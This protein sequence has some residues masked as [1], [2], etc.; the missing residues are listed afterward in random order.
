MKQRANVTFASVLCVLIVTAC[1]QNADYPVLKGPYLGQRPP[2]DVPVLFAP[3]IVADIY[4]EHSGA[5]FTPDGKELFWTVDNIGRPWYPRIVLFMKQVNGVWSQPEMASFVLGKITHI[6]SI[7][8]DGKRL[9]F[10]SVRPVKEGDEPTG[11]TWVID[12]KEMGWGVPYLHNTVNNPRTRLTD[13]QEAKSGTLY[14]YGTIGDDP[15]WRG[16]LRAKYSNGTYEALESLGPHVNSEYLDHSVT[17]DADEQYIIFA[18]QRP[19]GYS[20]QDLYISFRHPDDTWG[21]AHNL[22]EV[23]NT[24]GD[25]QA[26]PHLSSDGKYLFFV[27][28]TDPYP[29]LYDKQYSYQELRQISS[30]VM[31]GLSNIYWVSTGFVDSLKSEHF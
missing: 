19:G 12:K 31:N 6:N 14:G 17:V 5:V 11:N 16:I 4:R 10:G 1:S 20:A 18:S 29:D 21:P 2:G 22:G 23:I 26:W 7:S 24:T 30:G 8:P 9:Y 15:K 13:V 25:S 28:Q 3:G 27:S